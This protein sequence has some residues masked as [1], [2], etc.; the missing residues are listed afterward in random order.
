MGSDVH[1][2]ASGSGLHISVPSS[3]VT[4]VTGDTYPASHWMITV[5]PG[6]LL[7]TGPN[8]PFM[9]LVNTGQPRVYGLI[10]AAEVNYRLTNP[11]VVLSSRTVPSTVGSH[12]TDS[13]VHIVL[14][15]HSDRG[16]CEDRSRELGRR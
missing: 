14:S 5:D 1:A 13:V 8:A 4:I 9:G 11:K 16:R 7:E 3:H 2:I 10:F 12:N 6:N 15:S